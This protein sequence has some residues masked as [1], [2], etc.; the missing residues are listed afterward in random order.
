MSRDRDPNVGSTKGGKDR[1]ETELE[2][3]DTLIP[4]AVSS[5]QLSSLLATLREPGFSSRYDRRALIAKGG[6]GEVWVCAD[7]AIGREVALKRMHANLLESTIAQRRFIHEGRVQGQ[8]EHPAVVPVHELGVAPDGTPYFTMKL[9][10]GKTLEEVIRGLEQGIPEI[11]GD[12]SLRTLLT[13][14]EHICLAIE[15]A[16]ARGVVH[17]DLKPNNIM[18]GDYGELYV[19][20]WGIAK[21]GVLADDTTGEVFEDP[22]LA[23]PK[24]RLGGIIGTPGYMPPERF[25]GTSRA[26]VTDDVFALG[27]ILFEILTLEPLVPLGT[28]EEMRA[29]TVRGVEARATSRAADREIPPELEAICMR[30][31]AHDPSARHQSVRELRRQL[32]QYLEGERDRSLRRSLSVQHVEAAQDAL[33][34]S[35]AASP[36]EELVFRE[37]AVREVGKALALDL[38]NKRAMEVFANLVSEVPR[39]PPREVLDEIAAKERKSQRVGELETAIALLSWC[40]VLPLAL[41]AD[42]RNPVA[43]ALSVAGGITAAL[44]SYLSSRRDVSSPWLFWG[45]LFANLVAM[46]ATSRILGP[47]ILVPA[48]A[49]IAALLYGHHAARSRFWGTIILVCA[50]MILPLI[51]ESLGIWSSSYAFIEGNMVV[52]P[53]AT[54]LRPMPTIGSMLIVSVML[55]VVGAVYVHRTNRARAEAEALVML[56]KWHLTRL[57]S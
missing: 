43:I 40:A 47:F 39:K 31:T 55:V 24:T 36:E 28:I 6:M 2:V 5:A 51:L 29:A 23:P 41:W 54:E 38:E 17:R 32:T 50:T 42:A 19:L 13:T 15:F 27:A 44:L 9:V 4:P 8:L 46:C 22:A 49:V 30:A 45:S 53:N 37:R 3:A 26:A 20:D 16:H 7:L 14:F 11:V 48:I 52:R 25:S 57:F 12:Y 56:H 34:A 33:N 35:K 1:A 18:L 21:I 10:R